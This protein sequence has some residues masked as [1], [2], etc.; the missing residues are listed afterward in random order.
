MAL[1]SAAAAAV[2]LLLGAG[3]ARAEEPP[4]FLIDRITVEGSEQVSSAI[5]V[6]ES[7]L[8]PGRRYSEDELRQAVYRIERL[9]FVLAADFALRRGSTLGAYE[10][11]VTVTETSRFFVSFDLDVASRPLIDEG[12]FNRVARPDIVARQF[13]GTYGELVAGIGGAS[14]TDDSIELEG[15]LS[16]THYRLFGTRVAGTLTVQRHLSVNW[17]GQETWSDSRTELGLLLVAP[18]GA[19]HALRLVGDYTLPRDS[20]CWESAFEYCY[21][22]QSSWSGALEWVYDT[23]DDPLMPRVGMRSAVSVGSYR[24]SSGQR[25]HSPERGTLMLP[26]SQ[27]ERDDASV[28]ASRF[29]PLGPRQSLGIAVALK[30]SRWRDDNYFL[31]LDPNGQPAAWSREG[32]ERRGEVKLRHFAVLWRPTDRESFTTWWLESSAGF[33]REVASAHQSSQ[34]FPP[35]RDHTQGTS[36]VTATV[37]VAGRGRWGFVRFLFTYADYVGGR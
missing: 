2:L 33:A 18:F 26:D 15:F 17:S 36:E 32:D 21:F 27:S 16:A 4:T 11:V 31:Y 25:F 13:V 12:D 35:V 1:R 23:T 9:P 24:A 7:R 20:R 37:G 5:V 6:T 22:N 8:E 29:L 3:L 30:T 10:L 34:A 14:A 28:S 19:N